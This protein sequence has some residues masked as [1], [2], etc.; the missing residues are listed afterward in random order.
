MPVIELEAV[1]AALPTW[2]GWSPLWVYLPAALL[3]ALSAGLVAVGVLAPPVRRTRHAHWSEHARQVYNLRATL[4]LL[5]VLLP[6][7]FGLLPLSYSGE[8]SA[9]PPGVLSALSVGMIAATMLALYYQTERR[10][11]GSGLT[12]RRMLQGWAAVLLVLVPHL[13]VALGVMLAMP[14]DFGLATFALLGLTVA[15]TACSVAGGGL[16][17]ASWLGLATDV[18]SQIAHPGI[19]N[20]VAAA[21]RRVGIAPS[22]VFV[23]EGWSANAF[24]LPLRR[25]IGFTRRALQ[26]LTDEELAAITA[27]EL[28]HLRES[29][30]ARWS[31]A[32]GA[33]L[34][35]P[36]TLIGPLYHTL[37]LLGLGVVLLGVVAAAIVLKRMARALE[38]RADGVGRAHEHGAGAY[39]RALERLYAVNLV[40]AVLRG[41]RPHPSLYDRLVAAGAEPP[42]ERPAPPPAGRRL[43]ALVLATA[44]AVIV[45]G[46]SRGWLVS[47]LGD[48]EGENALLWELVTSE[49]AWAL[50]RLGDRYADAGQTD[51][52]LLFYRA[53]RAL[54]PQNRYY[55]QAE[56]FT[57]LAADR[58]AEAVRVARLGAEH[59]FEGPLGKAIDWCRSRPAERDDAAQGVSGPAGGDAEEGAEPTIKPSMS[60]TTS[61]VSQSSA[62]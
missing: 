17:A 26:E 11:V 38:Q 31:R 44:A 18:S 47:T 54:Q 22:R 12:A 21:A 20:V 7:A 33:F 55:V 25:W 41:R 29:A 50:G 9:L 58:C 32:L 27:H 45:F 42:Y 19:A 16:I 23:I 40:P 30:V 43:L 36:L 57:L 46:A 1:A 48:A 4:T 49:P 8:F 59:L 35:V 13:L 39:A 3:A 56:V 51:R 24:A 2:V 53:A 60:A 5:T 28:G 61:G 10:A 37:D 6:L 52:A 34:V 15:A 62:P 14:S